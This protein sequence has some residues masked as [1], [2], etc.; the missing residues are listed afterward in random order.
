MAASGTYVALEDLYAARGVKAF[1]KGETVPESNSY[2]A[3]WHAD[4]LLARPQAKAAK[5]AQ[6]EAG[7]E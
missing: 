3:D 2:A 1:S 4:G 7:D 6:A 5:A